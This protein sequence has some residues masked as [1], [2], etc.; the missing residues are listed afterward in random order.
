MK[1]FS[2]TLN[3]KGEGP[4]GRLPIGSITGMFSN[5]AY[6]GAA[7]IDDLSVLADWNATEITPVQFN[8]LLTPAATTDVPNPT[9]AL[10]AIEPAVRAYYA[11]KMAEVAKP[12]SPEERETWFAQV[13]EARAYTADA[14]VA[15]PFIS[16]IAAA[17]GLPVAEIAISIIAKDEQYRIAAGQI[18]GQQQ[19]LIQQIW[20]V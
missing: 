1:C 12:Y 6:Y 15:V 14:A 13:Q 8:T 17:R 9:P 3:E 19:N 5:G 7:V 18:L 20:T 10:T 16:T 4:A 11:N 2:Y